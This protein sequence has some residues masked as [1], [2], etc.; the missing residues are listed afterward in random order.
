MTIIE[1]TNYV[2]ILLFCLL[3]FIFLMVNAR[4][5]SSYLF[6]IEYF[7]T[8]TRRKL[9][10]AVKMTFFLQETKMRVFIIST[11]NEITSNLAFKLFKSMDN[12]YI[13]K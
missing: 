1:K 2:S 13:L 8:Y 12:F 6:Q 10:F 11:L 7:L 4:S 9:V 3:L 5:V